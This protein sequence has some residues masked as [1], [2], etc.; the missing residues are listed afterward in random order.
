MEKGFIS[1]LN[2]LHG[3]IIA[4]G[5]DSGTM[6]SAV[7]QLVGAPSPRLVDGHGTYGTLL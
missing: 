4:V 3:S 5:L 7:K 2:I 6:T 1:N